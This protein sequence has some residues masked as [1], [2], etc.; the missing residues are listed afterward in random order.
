MAAALLANAFAMTMIAIAMISLLAAFG[1]E[2]WKENVLRVGATCAGAYLVA[3]PFLP[4]SLFAAIIR[5]QQF[6]KVVQWEPRSF[7]AAAIVALG[8]I[9]LWQVFEWRRADWR[10]RFLGYLAWIT[11]SIPVMAR[12]LNRSFVPQPMR[13][14]VEA[15]LALALLVVFLARAVAGRWPVAVRAGFVLVLLGIGAAQVVSHRKFEKHLTMRAAPESTIEYRVARWA[16]EHLAAG[17]IWLPGSLGQWFNRWSASAQM[18]GSSFSTAY[19]KVHQ[20]VSSEFTSGASPEDAANVLTWLKA[21]GVQALAVPGKN[22]PEFWKVLGHPEIL[23]G[24]RC[25]GGRTTRRSAGCRGRRFRWGTWWRRT[26][27][28]GASRGTGGM[29]V[30][31]GGTRRRW[32]GRVMRACGG[33]ARMR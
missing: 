11:T 28:W 17:R 29:W 10:L 26:R 1:R 21:Y 23:R 4:P 25:C 33:T 18:T 12:H 9:V 6:H 7:T 16:G 13:Y 3:C 15:E 32:T 5:N 31:R 27:W 30:R 20:E 14:T 22:S 2:R 24:A 8:C 19:N